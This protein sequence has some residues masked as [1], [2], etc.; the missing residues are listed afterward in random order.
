MP[1]LSDRLSLLRT[2][3]PILSDPE[4]SPTSLIQSANHSAARLVNALVSHLPSHFSDTAPYRSRHISFHKRA[5]ILVADLWACFNGASYGRFDDID[6]ALTMFAD[7]RVPQML[8]SMG[9][10]WYSPRLEGRI[11][12]RD[13]LAPGEEMEVEIRACAIW[14]VE[15]M[16]REMQRR[17]WGVWEVEVEDDGDEREESHE[18]LDEPSGS[19]QHDA[20]DAATVA[21]TQL[22]T[23]TGT[24]TTE[25]L[26]GEPVSASASA[27]APKVR[28]VKMNVNAVLIDYLLYDTAKERE[29]E[30]LDNAER[31][32]GADGPQT[33]P[34]HR[35]RSI[36][37]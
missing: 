17:G 27:P 31:E 28:K 22:P 2:A 10:L 24:A 3:S 6:S 36:W 19:G 21:D 5:Q 18:N 33:L 35:T 4:T 30:M 15:L 12:R 37:Y 7:Y 25:A 13:L 8:Q 34:H 26:P 16:R 23:H 11:R 29:K 9:C 1:L 20:A 32:T 14:C